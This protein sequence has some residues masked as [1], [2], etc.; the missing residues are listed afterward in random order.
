MKN[1]NTLFTVLAKNPHI[2]PPQNLVYRFFQSIVNT[3]LCCS[4]IYEYK[5]TT[6]KEFLH[7]MQVYLQFNM[8]LMQPEVKPEGRH[9][10]IP[11]N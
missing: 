3:L 2:Y 10:S 7:Y 5:K 11:Q 1:E 6:L 8:D 4:C 9:I